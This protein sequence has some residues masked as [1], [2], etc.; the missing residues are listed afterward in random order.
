LKVYSITGQLV[1]T[2]EEGLLEAGWHATVWDG[3]DDSGRSVG[4][5]IYLYRLTVDGNRF[6]ATRR[7]LYLK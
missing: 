6:Q 2:L 7:M 5:G 4:T 3:R 1:A